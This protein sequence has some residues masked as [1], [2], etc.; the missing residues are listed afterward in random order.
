[1]LLPILMTIPYDQLGGI[2]S[3]PAILMDAARYS[4]DHGGNPFQRPVRLP[5]YSI[6]DNATTVICVQAE[7]AH[8]AHLNDYATYKV[9]ERGAAKF[10]CKTVD[11][12]WFNDLKTADTFYT[13][14]SALDIIAFLDAN[15]GGLHVI[16][17]ISLCT[18]MH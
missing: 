9:A 2:H 4:A 18:N 12:V 1:M 7:A 8:K 17:M 11:E 3:L 5:L 14:V 10:L 6:V 13:K 15:S 16:N